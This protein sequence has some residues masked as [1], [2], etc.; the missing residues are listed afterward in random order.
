MGRSSRTQNGLGLGKPRGEVDYGGMSRQEVA[1]VL[2]VTRARIGQI[3]RRA[4]AK[5]ERPAKK[6]R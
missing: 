2:K 5:L 6:L 1:N 3:E 4:L